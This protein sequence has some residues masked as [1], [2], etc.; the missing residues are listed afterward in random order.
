MSPGERVVVKKVAEIGSGMHRAVCRQAVI[1]ERP[2]K[3]RR[4]YRAVEARRSIGV[5]CT[6]QRQDAGS[7]DTRND[8][9]VC[10]SL[11]ADRASLAAYSKMNR[12]MGLQ[13]LEKVR[14]E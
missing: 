12:Y 4:G 6:A 13:E 1:S 5:D 3:T 2:R 14:D 9:I 11:D 10:A 8:A 7:I